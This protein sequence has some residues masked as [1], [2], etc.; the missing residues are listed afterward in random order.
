MHGQP[1]IRFKN[2]SRLFV[3]AA[4][5]DDEEILNEVK[6]NNQKVCYQKTIGIEIL[7]Y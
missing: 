4:C 3:H 1:H 6:K 7:W 5:F 2:T